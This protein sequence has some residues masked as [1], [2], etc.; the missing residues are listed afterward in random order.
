[1]DRSEYNRLHYLK[2]REAR[3]A[4]QKEYYKKNKESRNAY[5][6]QYS[7]KNRDSIVLQRK[8]YREENSESRKA[9][10]KKWYL[11]NADYAKARAKEYREANRQRMTDW[12]NQ[13]R[14]SRMSVDPVY[15]AAIR[16]R[17]LINIKIYCQGYT[18]KSRTFEILGCTYE[19][20]KE[21]IESQFTKGM[22]W[23]NHG[24]WHL[25][26]KIPIA[27]A[28]TEEDVIRLNYYSNF[29]PLWAHEN[30]KKGCKVLYD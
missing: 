3:L 12:S 15:K 9:A 6:K 29:Q 25:D 26:H 20:F 7:E 10:M 23:D 18:K 16:I 27:T 19:F 1:M 22:S 11:E 17:S 2:N 4:A 14:K 28:A 30:L 24:E 21:Y 13:Y 8:Q 5:N